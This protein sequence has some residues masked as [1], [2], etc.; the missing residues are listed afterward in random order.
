[1]AFATL[2]SR[3]THGE[4]Q[5][6]HLAIHSP[7]WMTNDRLQ[8]LECGFFFPGDLKNLDYLARKARQISSFA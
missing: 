6:W 1:M 5:Q 2:L 4:S 3:E 8:T 7:L